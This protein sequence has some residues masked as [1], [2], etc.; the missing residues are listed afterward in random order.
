MTFFWVSPIAQKNCFQIFFFKKILKIFFLFFRYDFRYFSRN[1]FRYF[2]FLHEYKNSS[3]F[4][5]SET[6]RNLSLSF[7]KKIPFLPKYA[8]DFFRSFSRNF[9]RKLQCS[10]KSFSRIF[11]R[12]ASKNSFSP[13]IASKILTGNI[14]EVF[15]GLI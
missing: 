12:N 3:G 13:E 2:W 5:F 4:Y 1:A 7:L 15:L 11:H 8:Q 9:F 14:L 10:S 6:L